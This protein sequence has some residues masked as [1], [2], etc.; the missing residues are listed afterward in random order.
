[1]LSD[2]VPLWVF[3]LGIIAMVMAALEGGFQLGRLAHR[4]SEDEKE[5]PVSVISGSVLGLGAFILAF[6]F[7]IVSN[8]FDDRKA[9]VRDEA[10][11]IRTAWLRSEFMSEP[12]RTE[13]K[14]LLRRY[15]EA[16][17]AFVQSNSIDAEQVASH[18][19]EADSIQRR[20]WG[21]AVANAR[22]DMNSDV[23]ALYIESVNDL[24]SIRAARV[25]VGLQLR[26]PAG[27]WCVLLA[28]ISL[29]MMGLGY[30]TGIAGSRRSFAQP[31]LA[32][33]FAVVI[34]LIADLD[35]AAG[36]LVQVTQQPLYN[37]HEWILSHP[38]ADGSNNSSDGSNDSSAGAAGSM[39]NS[40]T[41]TEAAP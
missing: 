29:G 41:P 7:G 37:L 11:A 9:L 33:S 1:M 25:S 32:V 27:I 36:A 40:S 14:K 26:I 22:K 20:L 18:L 30:Q 16:T 23:A 35:R 19:S 24:I 2:A 5:S 15:V 13:T 10:N 28:L 4:R 38:T 6:T 21:L 3:F 39:S 12:D 31:I 17:M 34:A 8:R